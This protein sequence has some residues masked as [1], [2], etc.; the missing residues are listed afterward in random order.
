MP[1]IFSVQNKG[2]MHYVTGVLLTLATEPHGI[3]GVMDLEHQIHY[4]E[5]EAYSSI[6]K[7]FI[8]QSDLL[9]WVN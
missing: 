6:L 1:L 3:R 7:A 5:T 4:L 2:L 9:T 8:A